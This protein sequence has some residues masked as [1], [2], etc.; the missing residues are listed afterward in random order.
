VS[1]DGVHRAATI[2]HDDNYIKNGVLEVE[3][4]GEMEVRQ[5][6]GKNIL[7]SKDINFQTFNT[8]LNL[9]RKEVDQIFLQQMLFFDVPEKKAKK[10]Y[11]GVRLF[12]G[13]IRKF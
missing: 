11:R 9:N 3:C 6:D 1:P 4:I 13:L 12:G 5:F 10:M 2:G 7:V 8:I